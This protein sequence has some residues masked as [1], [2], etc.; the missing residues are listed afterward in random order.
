MI[1][2]EQEYVSLLHQINNPNLFF[3]YIQ[4]PADEKIYKIDL[5]TKEIEAPSNLGSQGSHNSEI[6]WF[7]VDRFYDMR[8]LSTCACWI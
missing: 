4:I 1:V 8:D 2:S 7:V 3:N 5:N 6:I